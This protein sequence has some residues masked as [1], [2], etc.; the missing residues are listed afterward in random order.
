MC[1][2]IHARCLSYE[3]KSGI[4]GRQTPC[5]MA[6]NGV[7]SFVASSA[8]RGTTCLDCGTGAGSTWIAEGA[9]LGWDAIG[10]SC[11]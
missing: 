6:C 10:P 1:D 4:L 8:D 5:E 7:S 2:S 11:G 9:M 3:E